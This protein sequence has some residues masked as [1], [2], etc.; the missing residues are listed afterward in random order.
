MSHLVQIYYIRHF[1]VCQEVFRKK[2]NRLKPE[3]D[4]I[5][6]VPENDNMQPIVIPA[7]RRHELR[8]QGVATLVIKAL[9]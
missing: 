3:K 4:A 5:Y 7:E 9:K 1:F 2:F 6:L 8:I